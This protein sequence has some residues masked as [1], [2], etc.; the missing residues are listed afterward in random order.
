M[1]TGIR[2]T[3]TPAARTSVFRLRCSKAR[4]L[5]KRSL[6]CFLSDML[7]FLGGQSTWFTGKN[8]CR[9]ELSCKHFEMFGVIAKG[10]ETL[11]VLSLSYELSSSTDF[12]FV[13]GKSGQ[14]P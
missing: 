3:R 12:R 1:T 14:Q 4:P 8:P 7:P 13:F 2:P 6:R 10:P 9:F 5:L 11:L